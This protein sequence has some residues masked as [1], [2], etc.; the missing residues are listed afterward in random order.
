MKKVFFLL[1][2]GLIT[3]AHLTAQNKGE[4]YFHISQSLNTLLMKPENEGYKIGVGVGIGV[5]FD[6]FHS[7]RQFIHLGI[8][9]DIG[10]GS[11]FAKRESQRFE[12]FCLYLS[13]NHRIE[14]FSIGYGFSFTKNLWEYEKWIRAKG[15]FTG[16][17]YRITEVDVKK[18]HEAFG[19]IFLTNIQLIKFLNIGLVYRPTFYRLNMTDKKITYEHLLSVN[20]VL[21]I[22][23]KNK[24][25]E[26]I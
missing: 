21:K 19:L 17:P 12:S 16:L 23:M 15:Y 22:R 25:I 26:P 24:I 18:S 7:K 3:T 13:N 5:G 14:R 1:V 11:I 4:R 10:A 20:C 9:S 2:A 8:S 6:Y